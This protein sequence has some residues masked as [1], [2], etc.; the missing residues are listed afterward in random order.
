MTN[1]TAIIQTRTGS[2]RLPGKV[3]YPL[4]G[5]PVLEH[6]VRRTD[7]A[8]LVDAVIVATSTKEPDDVIAEYAPRFGAE[9][10]RGS[11]SDVLGRYEE[12]V[13]EYDPDLTIDITDWE[14]YGT[15]KSTRNPIERPPGVK[16]TKVGR[17]FAYS[18]QLATPSLTNVE[19]PFTT[20]LHDVSKGRHR[21]FHM[22]RLLD[23]AEA[24]V[25]K[26]TLVCVD[27]DF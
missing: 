15:P 21:G 26:P 5:R 4:D 16:G 22:Q 8:E 27:A 10:V 24:M 3:M 6:V 18:F 17:N 20:G 14:F 9:V 25:G 13:A 2:T 11:E 19:V 12:A 7:N 23:Y 1:T